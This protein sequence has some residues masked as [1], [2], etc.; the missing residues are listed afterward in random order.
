MNATEQRKQELL[1]HGATCR[2]AIK[3]GTQELKGGVATTLGNP[4]GPLQAVASTVFN[5]LG[6]GNT[7]SIVKV[8]MPLAATA[9][10][11]LSSKRLLKPALRVSAVAGIVAAGYWILRKKQKT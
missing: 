7:S 5:A 9:L 1:E 8:A 2:E 11:A 3:A 4:F 10:S 6:T